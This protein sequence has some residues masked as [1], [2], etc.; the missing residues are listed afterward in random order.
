MSCAHPVSFISLPIAC[1]DAIVYLLSDV[2]YNHNSI[3]RV[4]C[5]PFLDK[6]QTRDDAKDN[7]IELFLN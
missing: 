1:G 7:K 3:T 6:D 4:T 5:T 2:N